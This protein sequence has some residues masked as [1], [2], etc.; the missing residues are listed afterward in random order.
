MDLES[1][2]RQDETL[3]GTQSGSRAGASQVSPAPKSPFP[4]M[5]TVDWAARVASEIEGQ[6]QGVRVGISPVI[7]GL[8]VNLVLGIL[9][10]CLMAHM[11]RQHRIVNRRPDGRVATAMKAE[12]GRAF[13]EKH[14]DQDS[15][16]VKAHVDSTVEAFREASVTELTDLFQSQ[17]ERP[18]TA[19]ELDASWPY[20]GAAMKLMSL[21]EDVN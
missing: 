14:P 19:E 1:Q 5:Q 7:V 10:Q 13:L 17:Q 2:E 15:A 12:I 21:D 16:S 4:E 6:H 20:A 8:L 3:A 9:K 11:L 18:A